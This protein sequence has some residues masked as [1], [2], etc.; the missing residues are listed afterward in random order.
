MCYEGKILRRVELIGTLGNLFYCFVY[1]S[2]PML[3]CYLLARGI[4]EKDRTALAACGA[5]SILILWFD[6]AIMFKAPAVIYV[7]CLGITLWLSGFGFVKSAFFSGAAAVS[8]Y[9]I[10]SLMQFCD[11]QGKSWD[12]TIPAPIAV[13]PREVPEEQPAKTP[14]QTERPSPGQQAITAP[15]Q[16]EPA[17]RGLFNKAGYMARAV[18]FR[19]ASGYPYYLQTFSD[20]AAECGIQRPR[21][22]WLAPQACFGPVVIFRQMYPS[23]SYTTGY[24][25]A[26][27][28]V[29]AYSEAGFG[30]VLFATMICG[31]ILGALAC[32]VRDRSALSIAFMIASITYAYYAT[33][34]SLTGSLLDSYGLLWLLFPI[35]V[36]ITVGYVI[37]FVRQRRG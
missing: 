34:A 36:M 5:V 31:I 13:S 23:I 6:V 16:A 30:Y 24:Q 21:L 12:R 35:A 15:H 3:G 27:L 18:L 20:P 1:S 9:V 14:Q 22:R 8:L 28:N 4:R 32:L 7:G 25:P 2:L 19:M 37:E 10:L 33:Q 11:A 29:F 17:Q 26:P